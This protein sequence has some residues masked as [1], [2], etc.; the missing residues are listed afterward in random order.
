M[1]V[2]EVCDGAAKPRDGAAKHST[3]ETKQS[4]F[5]YKISI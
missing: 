2:E 3:V 1:E 5:T 4:I